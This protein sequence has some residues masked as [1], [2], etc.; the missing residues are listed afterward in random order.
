LVPIGV[1]PDSFLHRMEKLPTRGGQRRWRN[2][3]GSRIYTWD[4]L[5]GEV[6]VFNARGR[7]IGVA[8]AVT[9]ETMKPAKKGRSID[10]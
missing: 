4:A 3:D 8:D 9:G 1:P 2:G 10:V 6:E 5:H 7:H